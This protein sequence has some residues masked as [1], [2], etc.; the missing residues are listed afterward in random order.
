MPLS[1]N[2]MLRA[3][4]LLA[5]ALLLSACA[6]PQPLPPVVVKPPVVPPLPATSKQPPR[7]PICTPTCL[8]GLERLLLELE[9]KLNAT[10]QP[11]KDV[12]GTTTP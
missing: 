6:T 2:L 5:L 4:M 1:A 11:A 12:S 9:R 8:Q 7:S 10:E 3:A